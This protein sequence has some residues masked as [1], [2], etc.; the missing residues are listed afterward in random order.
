MSSAYTGN[1]AHITVPATV[2]IT[3]PSDGDA[4][5]AA[6]VNSPGPFEYTAD[7]LAY[8]YAN[9]GRLAA[10]NTWSALQTFSSVAINGTLTLATPTVTY[11]AL[12]TGSFQTGCRK[13]GMWTDVHGN[14]HIEGKVGGL[15]GTHASE[16]IWADHTIPS[17]FRPGSTKA[18]ELPCVCNGGTAA[19]MMAIS[20]QGALSFSAVG[21]NITTAEVS[22]TISA[23][24]ALA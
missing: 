6:S 8:V 14:L 13:L 1:P 23:F 21:T 19:G 10:A 7:Y 5:T 20:D 17:A 22:V 18:I 2:Q 24:V 12:A 16:A 11:P 9:F 4:G 3:I 15:P